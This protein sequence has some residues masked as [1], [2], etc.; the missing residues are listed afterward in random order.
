MKHTG[1]VSTLDWN[2][3]QRNLLASGAQNSEIYI[4]D[5]NAPE[6]PMTPGA[7][8]QPL[9][10]VRHVRWNAKIQHIL[11]SLIG[12]PSGTQAVIWDLR[13]NEPIIKITDRSSRLSASCMAW[14]PNNPTQFAVGS[15][16]SERPVVQLW[17][18]R[19]AQQP[20]QIIQGNQKGV[21]TMEWSREDPRLI[22]TGAKDGRALIFN[23]SDGAVISEMPQQP[24]FVIASTF[25][26]R[27]PDLVTVASAEGGAQVFDM[28]GQPSAPKLQSQK[29]TAALD[30][31][32]GAFDAAPAPVAPIEAPCPEPCSL[33]PA[34]FGRRVG[35]AFGFGG[36]LVSFGNGKNTLKLRQI[37]TEPDVVEESKVLLQSLEADT[38]E[39]CA[40]KCEAAQDSKEKSVWKY[41]HARSDDDSRATFLSLLGVK[42]VFVNKLVIFQQSQEGFDIVDPVTSPVEQAPVDESDPFADISQA[43]ADIPATDASVCCHLYIGFNIF[44][45]FYPAFN[46]PTDGSV[47]SQIAQAL[48]VSNIDTAVKICMDNK[49]FSDAL[50]IAKIGGPELLEST[51]QTYHK[52]NQSPIAGLLQTIYANNWQRIAQESDLKNWKEAVSSILTYVPDTELPSLLDVIASR[53]EASGKS[54]EAAAA[55]IMSGNVDKLVSC[56]K[57]FFYT[58]SA[59]SEL[60]LLVEKVLVLR[61]T[62]NATI[63]DESNSVLESYA[64]LLAAQGEFAAAMEFCGG[65]SEQLSRLRNRI[66]RTNTPPP[67]AQTQAAQNT[68]YNSYNQY[69]NQPAVPQPVSSIPTGPRTNMRRNK[70]TRSHATPSATPAYTPAPEPTSHFAP[71]PSQ[72]TPSFAPASSGFTPAPPAPSFSQPSFTPA[73]VSSPS[74]SGFAPP[75]G[76][77]PT[78]ATSFQPTNSAVMPPLNS[79][80]MS[81]PSG[82]PPMG[83]DISNIPTGPSPTKPPSTA[84]WND[85]KNKPEYAKDVDSSM[86]LNKKK[87]APTMT[88]LDST[89]VFQPAPTPVGMGGMPGMSPMGM[90]TGMG[91]APPMGGPAPVMPPMGGGQSSSAQQLGGMGSVA[92]APLLEQYLPIQN[93]MDSLLDRCKQSPVMKPIL[94]KKID[95]AQK[96][97]GMLYDKLRA[98]GCSQLVTDAL[99]QI[100]EAAQNHDYN[101]GLGVVQFIVQKANFSEVSSFL[102]GVKNLL[103]VASQLKV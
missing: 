38:K 30:D 20:Y 14:N 61:Q 79:P 23:V 92:K 95:D 27:H 93:A 87:K 43:N 74:Q 72:P 2:H 63:G 85:P 17:D 84:G 78:P 98:G 58:G 29:Q 24:G 40:K 65:A 67:Q 47:D 41:I 59:A 57:K 103:T 13:K 45:G 15:E 21:T 28:M 55:Y 81:Q 82:G 53:L 62:Q 25:N 54:E 66:L 10:P 89:N 7:K 56:L 26:R 1:A 71:T 22:L 60:Q 76:F 99:L 70:A 73:P 12:L 37:I 36:K 52:K 33:P 46:I 3:Y 16:D 34:W 91:A 101:R 77:N 64:M 94:K 31:A 97:L 11:G 90:P 42:K 50:I 49:R 88:T 86:R 8:I 19:Q 44:S 68:G 18:V 51:I 96:R 35:A 75:S 39:Y 80:M 32:F 100:S 5:M 83:A 69:Q 9:S 102:P 48:L 6:K 4:W